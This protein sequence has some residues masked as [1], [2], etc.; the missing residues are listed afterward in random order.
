[1]KIN[2]DILLEAISETM[3]LMAF[4]E[5]IPQQE[6]DSS[7]LVHSYHSKII[8]HQAGSAM[9]FHLII[10]AIFAQEITAQ[11]YADATPVLENQV[12][13]DAISELNN[14]IAGKLMI[15]LGEQDHQTYTLS[16]P[17]TTLLNEEPTF[18]VKSMQLQVLL[19]NQYSL[20][21]ILEPL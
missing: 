7:L 12:I 4:F 6:F 1:M 19:D 11:M 9:Q 15:L 20:S 14:T 8:I 5:T 18:D 21:T 17:H 13:L 10:P 16:I 3:E 2:Q